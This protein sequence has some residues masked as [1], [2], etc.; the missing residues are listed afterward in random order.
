MERNFRRNRR[1][2]WKEMEMNE[3]RDTMRIGYGVNTPPHSKT[4][5]KPTWRV[6][7]SRT[8][9]SFSEQY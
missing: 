7:G 5:I 9:L 8:K 3:E 4:K 2:R 6:W 1:G